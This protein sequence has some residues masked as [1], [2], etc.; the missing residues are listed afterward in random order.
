MTSGVWALHYSDDAMCPSANKKPRYWMTP[1]SRY[2]P[3]GQRVNLDDDR[4][5]FEQ[6]LNGQ[7]GFYVRFYGPRHGKWQWFQASKLVANKKEALEAF[8]EW[9]TDTEEYLANG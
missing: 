7:Y 4:L 6:R 1:L 8:Y 2:S 9:V 5:T 3:N